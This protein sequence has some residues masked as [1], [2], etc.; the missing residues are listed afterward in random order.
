MVNP[1]DSNNEVKLIFNMGEP[2]QLDTEKI[3]NK[4]TSVIISVY[5]FP[6]QLY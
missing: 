2:Q 3:K 4:D 6:S 5:M 1:Y